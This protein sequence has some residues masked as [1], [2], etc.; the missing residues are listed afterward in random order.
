MKFEMGKK[1]F[2]LTH[3]RSNLDFALE[4]EIEYLNR[5]GNIVVD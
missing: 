3:K 4:K 1:H 2:S 5:Y